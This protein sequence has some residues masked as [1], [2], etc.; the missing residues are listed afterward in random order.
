M[1]IFTNII[2]KNKAYKN[3]CY[4]KSMKA[5]RNKKR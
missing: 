2:K 1:I 4:K 3:S 5:S